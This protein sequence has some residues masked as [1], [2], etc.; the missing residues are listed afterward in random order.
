MI[1]LLRQLSAVFQVA[2]VVFLF[3]FAMS[4]IGF[5]VHIDFIEPQV[6]VALGSITITAL[7][8]VF[9]TKRLGG[10]W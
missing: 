6:L 8:A 4:S 3:W 2:A 10:E 9:V 7:L 5:A 1:S